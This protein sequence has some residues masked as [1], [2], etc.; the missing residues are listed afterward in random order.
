MIHSSDDRVAHLTEELEQV[1]RELERLQAA[2][3]A[4]RGRGS[5]RPGRLWA[6]APLLLLGTWVLTAQTPATQDELERRV[7]ELE[8]RLLKGPGTTTRIQ[9]PFEVVGAGG[10]VIL[11]VK[12]GLPTA[13][14]GVAIFSQ[15]KTAGVTVNQGGKDIAGLG[16]ADNGKGGL[17]FIADEYGAPRAEI[18]ADGGVSVLNGSGQ[19][20]AAM[21]ALSDGAYSG[22]FAVM[23]GD[24][25]IASLEGT[26]DGGLLDIA[27]ERG[28]SKAQVGIDDANG[29]ISTLDPKGYGEVEMGV[30]EKGE[31]RLAL[32]DKG[33][34]R[35]SLGLWTGAGLLAISNAKG[36]AVA[37]VRGDGINSS[38]AVIVGN[39]SGKGVAN[40]TAGADGSGLV[41]I[42]QPGGSPIAVLTQ[43][44]AGGLLQIKS[45]AGT[46]VANLKTGG[47]G[48]GYLQLTNPAGTAT[49][50]AGTEADG[51]GTV[52]AGPYYK[53]STRAAAAVMVGM[54]SLPD[55]IQGRT[56]P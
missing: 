33:K 56:Q 52:K 48:G 42:F 51:R 40:M 2:G 49:V 24:K 17:V 44:K 21:L 36:E 27:D 9:A 38:G 55:C 46:P 31:P 10:S 34:L 18:R 11:Q 32:N 3:P 8:A 43:D 22:R 12:Q 39:G 13:N 30:S 41:Q 14:D 19:V 45:A 7:S 23:H 47:E 5:P 4:P 53:C 26:S 29:Y 1:R 50:E 54:I 28:K 37:N 35:A 6:A 15:G 25:L 16:T 20:V